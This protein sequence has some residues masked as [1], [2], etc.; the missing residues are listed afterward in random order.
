ML[1]VGKAWLASGLYIPC[2]I[3]GFCNCFRSVLQSGD[4][5]K[6]SGGILNAD[7]PGEGERGDDGLLL[8]PD[9]DGDTA[10]VY[11]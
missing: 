10:A 9:R 4:I 6:E 2:V 1:R 7:Q 8:I 5:F 3:E 11:G